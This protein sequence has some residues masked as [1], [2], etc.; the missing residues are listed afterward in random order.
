[1]REENKLFPL[2]VELWDVYDEDRNLT[3]RLHPRGVPLQEGDYH[4]VV[5]AWM[6]NSR[7]EYLLTRRTPNKT[8]P[9]MW[10]TTGGAAQAGDDSLSAVLREAKEETGLT[11]DP[12]KG[13]L[14]LSF[15]SGNAFADVWLFEQDFD[16]ADVVF[17]PGE[18]CGAMYASAEKIYQMLQEGI[19][20][21]CS[22]LEQLLESESH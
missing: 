9:G 19:L 15:K 14:F 21:P 11:L 16:L 17:Q 22:Y 10:E 12:E 7:G 3:G 5:Q 1:M 20:V 6:R 4:L 13:S 2:D 8:Y 18:T